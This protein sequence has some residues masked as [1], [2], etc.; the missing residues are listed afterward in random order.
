MLPVSRWDMP[1][2]CDVERPI[3]RGLKRCKESRHL[4][5]QVGTKAIQNRLGI[6][7]ME[8][9]D[10]KR[11]LTLAFALLLSL[12]SMSAFAQGGGGGGGG[13]SSSGGASAGGS[14][15]RAASGPTGGAASPA[16][17]P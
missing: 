8:E 2:S 5:A 12:G 4:T 7:P 1:L 11:S 6:K 14:A 13:G 9:S 10:M 3:D 15:A 16:G 17:S